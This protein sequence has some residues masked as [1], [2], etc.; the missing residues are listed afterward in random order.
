MNVIE[1]AKEYAKGK[2]LGVISYAIVQAYADGYN[3]GY[4]KGINSLK[5]IM[6]LK[7]PMMLVRKTKTYNII[8]AV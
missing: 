6:G 8:P 5:I 3:E 1:K 4:N 2:A 7:I